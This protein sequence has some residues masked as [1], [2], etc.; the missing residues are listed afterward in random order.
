M[1]G[2]GKG[3]S[4]TLFMAFQEEANGHELGKTGNL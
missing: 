1:K 4:V 2:E 3:K